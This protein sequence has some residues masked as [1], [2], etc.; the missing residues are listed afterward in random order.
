VKACEEK[1]KSLG[2][3]PQ[4]FLDEG[5]PLA[6]YVSKNDASSSE[7]I[8]SI[9]LLA[10]FAIA[11]HTEG[12]ELW[13]PFRFGLRAWKNFSPFSV[14][15]LKENL[16]LLSSF[17][18]TLQRK[19]LDPIMSLQ[20][21]LS[22]APK[23]LNYNLNRFQVILKSAH[24]LAQLDQNPQRFL[25]FVPG[26]C[27]NIAGEGEKDFLE[28]IASF[29][30]FVMALEERGLGFVYPFGL[31]TYNA[32]MAF[33]GDIKN[34]N[35]FLID[36]LE[37]IDLLRSNKLSSYNVFEY[38]MLAYSS[39]QPNH[40]QRELVMESCI[41]L[42]S[43]GVLPT[44]IVRQAIPE[45]IDDVEYGIPLF[46][47]LCRKGIDSSD[48]FVSLWPW[49]RVS[50]TSGA[51]GKELLALIE[52]L[53]EIFK[54]KNWDA[55]RFFKEFVSSIFNFSQ[56]P[57]KDILT[58]ALEMG[59]KDF[60]PTG[61]LQG[62]F[63]MMRQFDGDEKIVAVFMKFAW[64]ELNKNI[65][66]TIIFQGGA[67]SAFVVCKQNMKRLDEV[68]ATLHKFI[69]KA[70]SENLFN[71]G[72]YHIA[73]LLRNNPD[74][75]IKT[76]KLLDEKIIEL[77]KI[78]ARAED[79]LSAILLTIKSSEDLIMSADIGI[80][81]LSRLKK[82]EIDISEALTTMLPVLMELS[83]SLSEAQ[84][85]LDLLEKLFFSEGDLAMLKT[86]LC[87]LMN[88]KSALN[89]GK[90]NFLSLLE[91]LLSLNFSPR[92][93]DV[94]LTENLSLLIDF[95]S[96][97]VLGIFKI[98]DNLKLSE[99][100]GNEEFLR[101]FL[102]S[103]LAASSGD[104]QD[105]HSSSSKLN[106]FVNRKNPGPLCLIIAKKCENVAA[107]LQFLEK[108]NFSFLENPLYK[109]Y[110]VE[111]LSLQIS[112]VVNDP[113]AFLNSVKEVLQM[114]DKRFFSACNLQYEFIKAFPAIRVAVR[115]GK[116][117]FMQC[118]RTVHEL[119]QY[120]FESRSAGIF[121]SFLELAD[122]FENVPA[123]WKELIVPLSGSQGKGSP[124][125][126]R[127]YERLASYV[128]KESDLVILKYI[129]TQCGVRAIDIFYEIVQ[130]ALQRSV[131]TDLASEG[132][133]IQEFVE[134]ISIND[135]DFFLEFLKL[136]RDTSIGPIERREKIEKMRLDFEDLM[137]EIV[138]GNI[139]PGREE[140]PAFFKVMYYVF[141]PSYSIS[142]EGYRSLY[143]RFDDHTDHVKAKSA[144]KKEIEKDYHFAEGAYV[145]KEGEVLNTEAWEF[146]VKAMNEATSMPKE[147]NLLQLGES[148]FLSWVQ[149]ELTI[150]KKINLTA[151]IYKHYLQGHPPLEPDL[152]QIQ[153]LFKMKS[154]IENSSQ[155]VIHAALGEY[156]E[157]Y[158]DR[159]LSY[160][161]NK[162]IPLKAVGKGLRKS[163]EKTIEDY[164]QK[165]I[166]GTVAQE[167]LQ[168]QLKG[169]DCSVANFFPTLLSS[170]PTRREE[171]LN[172]LKAEAK[173]IDPGQ[174]YLRV[175]QDALGDI[176]AQMQ[177]E[178]FGNSTQAP[179][180]EYKKSSGVN[181]LKMRFLVTKKKAHAAVGF[182]EGVCTATD[183]V[184]WD[185]PQFMQVA[186]WGP[187]QR[188]YG[189]MHVLLSTQKNKTYLTLPG[190]NPSMVFLKKV[191]AEEIFDEMINF[192]KHLVQ[193]WGLDGVWIPINEGI[194]SNRMEIQQIIREKKY[195]VKQVEMV[196]FS[197]SPYR[198]S[199]CTVFDV[200]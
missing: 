54:D 79:V 126:M 131:I 150:E 51:E 49:I 75:F 73:L 99:K 132:R 5:V 31:G 127:A 91:N 100:N 65:N 114:V 130:V 197:V 102:P 104:Y 173:D 8:E 111:E 37:L 94:F 57:Q 16:N 69:L 161:R 136:S 2:A 53:Y 194:H 177:K 164:E 109:T 87:N 172:T 142:T 184:L 93:N 153:N 47:S 4:Y 140:H 145:L 112:S 103:V 48:F 199:F 29:E 7:F 33:E 138:S 154:F 139:T 85:N 82:Y 96:E 200:K 156:F 59:K 43:V 160:S 129:V 178:F 180:M 3:D 92:M 122:F 187:D 70:N 17:L 40:P 78:D 86:A 39:L 66:P 165:K 123:A 12:M 68:V 46:S 21:G 175:F 176:S 193:E 190:L 35:I 149:N 101:F 133:I 108:E 181:Q 80:M 56:S 134:K 61:A 26:A 9:N 6:L 38:G 118:F 81:L 72:I 63:F 1:L 196:D 55:K 41:A 24:A 117:D 182:C 20:K 185:R 146:V 113:C 171:I 98:I 14:I 124:A 119:A 188:C 23:I 58:L 198:Y 192:A 62:L 167:R 183:I 44:N 170:A 32:S 95:S 157:A 11:L 89:I 74:E 191:R 166:S 159:F 88:I 27:Q 115:L 77:K 152:G 135:F 64:E 125:I 147:L 36:C 34:F 168:M 60:N 116:Q 28:A 76:I 42:A 50:R 107:Y 137:K 83:S 151:S 141:T 120:G 110:P 143:A 10:E 19:N 22:S 52:N 158:P 15:Q 105:F 121:N 18:I 174:V 195:E 106:F 179:K 71:K 25:E 128:E 45:V 30:K 169:F 144:E 163:I 189:G 90:D 162:I 97:E 186:F 13:N 84:K 148:L 155:E 67:N